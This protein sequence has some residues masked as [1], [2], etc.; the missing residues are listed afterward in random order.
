M[1]VVF[2][3][4]SGSHV[5]L[6]CHGAYVA[7]A[8]SVALAAQIAGTLVGRNQ[9]GAHHGRPRHVKYVQSCRPQKPQ[10]SINPAHRVRIFLTMSDTRSL[11]FAPFSKL[12]HVDDDTTDRNLPSFVTCTLKTVRTSNVERRAMVLHLARTRES[13]SL[14]TPS[15]FRRQASPTCVG[16]GQRVVRVSMLKAC[17]FVSTAQFINTHPRRRLERGRVSF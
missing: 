8:I 10:Q 6:L 5:T 17:R 4:S 14:F 9:Q 2:P 12:G 7:L 11:L 3:R 16:Q 15:P 1:P 13:A